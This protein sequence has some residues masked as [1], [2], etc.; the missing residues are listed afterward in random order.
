MVKSKHKKKQWCRMH[1]AKWPQN[2]VAGPFE[3]DV[4]LCSNNL[5]EVGK[6]LKSCC[7]EMS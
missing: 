4:L 1:A 3:D 5:N 7:M 6:S 2:T